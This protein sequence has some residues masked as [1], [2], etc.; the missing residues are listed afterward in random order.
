MILVVDDEQ[1]LTDLIALALRYERFEVALRYERF[2]VALAHTGH[3]GLTALRSF[4]PDL[5]VLDI[6]LPD[7]DGFEV[8]RR[9]ASESPSTPVLFLTARDAR[10][11]TT[12]LACRPRSP[13]TSSSRSTGPRGPRRARNGRPPQASDWP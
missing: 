9:M 8:A 4:R 6:M 13:S 11:A 5:V 1:S 7:L 12:A 3:Q 2:E 10:C